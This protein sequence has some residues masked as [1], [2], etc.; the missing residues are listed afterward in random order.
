MAGWVAQTFSRA[1][2]YGFIHDMVF[3]FIGSV[4]GGATVWVVVSSKV[5]M[6]AMLLIGCGGA[7]HRDRRSAQILGGARLEGPERHP[8]PGGRRT[9]SAEALALLFQ[10][11]RELQSP[12]A[13]SPSS[14]S[15]LTTVSGVRTLSLMFRRLVG[16]VAVVVDN[17]VPFQPYRS[18][19]HLRVR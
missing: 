2:R 14:P 18:T 5:G 12:K 6:L 4:I 16:A 10:G 13:W 17:S 3:G 8:Q 15:Q 19:R 11:H 7:G 9:A 1:D